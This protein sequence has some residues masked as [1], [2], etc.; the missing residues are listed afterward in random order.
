MNSSMMSNKGFAEPI[1]APAETVRSEE[2]Q[3]RVKTDPMAADFDQFGSFHDE[4]MSKS[5]IAENQFDDFPD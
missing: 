2:K 5:G 1:K 4:S 3:E